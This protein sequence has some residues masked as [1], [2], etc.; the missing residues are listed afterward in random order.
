[1]RCEYCQK[2]FPIDDERMVGQDIKCP[3]CGIPCH[4]SDRRVIIICPACH[5][6]MEGELW[7]LGNHAECTYCHK[8]ILLSRPPNPDDEYSNSYLPGN[9]VLGNYTIKRCVGAGGMGEVYLARHNFLERDYALKLLRPDRSGTIGDVSLESLIREAR[10]ACQVQSPHIISVT[11]VQVDTE[12]N[13]SYIVMEYVEGRNIESMICEQPLDES[14]VIEV[15]RGVCQGL[16]A[17]ADY[18]I[19]HRDIKPANIMLTDGG[20]VKLADLGIAKSGKD[21]SNKSGGKIVGTVNYCAPEQLLASD[22]VDVRADIYSLGATMYHMLSG[23]RPFEAHNTKTVISKVLKGDLLPLSKVAPLV[24]KD[25]CKLVNAMMNMNVDK[26]PAD[27]KKLLAAL[28]IIVKKRSHKFL[29]YLPFYSKFAALTKMKKFFVL[30]AASAVILLAGAGG[31]ALAV[32]QGRSESENLNEQKMLE[33]LTTETAKSPRTADGKKAPSDTGAKPAE[34][35]KTATDATADAKPAEKSTVNAPAMQPDPIVIVKNTG[36]KAADRKHTVR[37]V[38]TRKKIVSRSVKTKR[39][40]TV[41]QPLAP[42]R[43]AQ[44]DEVIPEGVE[45]LAE[46][47]KNTKAG[48]I[49][50]KIIQIEMVK[51]IEEGKKAKTGT[52]TDESAPGNL[53]EAIQT[54]AAKAKPA[55]SAPV[56]TTSAESTP[57]ETKPAESAPAETKPAEN[58]P[59]ETKPAAAQPQNKTTAAQVDRGSSKVGFIKLLCLVLWIFSG[60]KVMSYL[61]K[62]ARQNNSFVIRNA[63][64]L[65]LASLIAGPIVYL[66]VE[67]HK[68]FGSRIKKLSF[69]KE[70]LPIIVDNHGNPAFM[71]GD[72]SGDSDVVYYVRKMLA[73]ALQLHASD[74]FIDPKTGEVSVIRFRVDGALRVIEEINFEFGNRVINVFKVA[75][76]MDISERRRPQDGAFSLTGPFGDVSLRVAT[77]GAFSGEKIALRIL[78]DDSGPKSLS[79]AGLTGTELATMEQAAKLPSGMVLICG[80][81]GSGKT[82]TLYAMLN[83]IDYSIKN[84]ISI[85]DP[86]EHVIPAISQMEV[87]ESAGIGFSQL[88][89]NALRQNPDIICLGEIRDEDTAQTAIHAAQTGH[90][91][92]AT[93]HS[94]DNIGT[95]DRLANLNIPLRSIA[96]TL[97]VVVSQRLVRKLCSCKKPVAPSEEDRLQFG[98]FGISCSKLYE[99]KGCPKCGNTGYSGRVALFDILTVDDDLRELLEDEHTNLSNIQKRLKK[100]TG[101][102]AMIRSGYVLAAKGIT[103]TEEVR[104]VT[105]EIK[106]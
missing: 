14:F 25:C 8:E 85:E 62:N 98:Q 19:V 37:S 65:N 102:S 27:A 5:R 12:R 97:R 29:S 67:Y 76:G 31:I 47:I 57:A 93:L 103:S 9:Y 77:V 22:D 95:I 83:S 2:E 75:G 60:I 52:Q 104:R 59:A 94:N 43:P 28:D 33:L 71:E 7:M 82:T 16:I 35:E 72:S 66:I 81:T 17:A 51:I 1:M 54:A 105:M 11:D 89:R 21:N 64:V 26:R 70:P 63:E 88:L 39:V 78:G 10:L 90:L 3:H 92:I 50:Q 4:C 73:N 58:K 101:G 15:A 36:E 79:A 46:G 34:K 68:K 99:P 87:N 61:V 96:G 56:E 80:P 41:Q 38:K 45:E 74:I 40:K 18:D 69:K 53:V 23:R 30:A 42:V 48:R 84:V 106:N 55:E 6:D 100:G 86:I 44:Y 24:S 49:G 20:V 91:I 32:G 13:L